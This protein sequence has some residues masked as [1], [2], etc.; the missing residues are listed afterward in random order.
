MM[1]FGRLEP[2]AGPSPGSTFCACGG[3]GGGAACG[4]GGGGAVAPSLI[5]FSYRS[6]RETPFDRAWLAR[7]SCESMT[8]LNDSYGIAPE[9]RAPLMKKCGV[10]LAPSFDACA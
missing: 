5:R 9:I 3:G 7:L 2:M 10:P 6:R 1:T 4:G 8:A